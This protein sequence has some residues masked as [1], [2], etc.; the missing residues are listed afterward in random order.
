M[1]AP[2]AHRI[3]LF[4]L[5]LILALATIGPAAAAPTSAES[6]K[7]DHS[8]KP[9]T[10]VASTESGALALRA[11]LSHSAY[12]Q[13]APTQLLFKVDYAS[14]AV[15]PASRPPL[16][17][18]LVLDRSGSMA[19]DRKFVYTLNAAREVIANL[20]DRDTISLIAF[21]EQVLVLS[22]AGR[23]VNKQFLLHRLEEIEPEGYTDISAGLLEGIAQVNSQ[24]AEGQIKQVLLL[25]DGKANR[26]VTGVAS[27]RKTVEKARAKGVGLSTLGCGTDYD[28]KLL[29]E[30]ASAGGG[31]YT[32]VRSPEQ[33]P[34]A[35][36]DELHGL[37]EVVAQN[38]RLELAVEQGAITKVFGQVWESP[39]PSYQINVGNLRAGERGVVLLALKPSDYRDGAAIR[40]TAKLN[41]DD[42][43][44]GE[45]VVRTAFA[46]ATFDAEATQK[47]EANE[48]VV[49]YGGLLGALETATEG[50]EGYDE[51]SY[52]QALTGFAQ[53]YGRARQLALNTRNQDLLNHTFLLKHFLEEMEAAEKQGKMHAHSE[54][55]EKLKK[56]SDY[57]RYLLLHHR[58]PE[59]P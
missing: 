44:A 19:E 46:Q 13:S 53:W 14:T 11:A 1:K 42:P 35:F 26:G 55:L 40:V 49:I 15:A 39:V 54:A 9:A 32:Y 30:M 59:K 51:Q 28:E 17:I 47:S 34:D 20:S 21:N 38:A 57:Q 31:R 3:G 33:I 5:L 37:L 12:S 23:A 29:T 7:H 58:E 6:E 43:Q 56:E 4:L 16:N 8:N 22:P 10:P 25:T 2:T 24:A 18:A 36:K 41:F 48:E 27:L 50:A 45:R 52:R